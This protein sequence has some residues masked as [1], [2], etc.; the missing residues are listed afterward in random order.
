[1]ADYSRFLKRHAQ[2]L[3]EE[4]PHS[5]KFRRAKRLMHPEEPID[6]SKAVPPHIEAPKPPPV[7]ASRTLH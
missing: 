4:Q 3:L 2:R 1:M 7:L 6:V 5:E